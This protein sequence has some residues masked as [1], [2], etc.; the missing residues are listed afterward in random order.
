MSKNL[1]LGLRREVDENCAITQRV[2]ILSFR[3]FGATY[4]VPS[5]SVPKRR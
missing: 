4:R 1:V 5:L 3:R 2:V